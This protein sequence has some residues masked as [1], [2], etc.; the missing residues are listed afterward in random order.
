MAQ[1]NQQHGSLTHKTGSAFHFCHLQQP[2][3][4]GQTDRQTAETE[5]GR[6]RATAHPQRAES[7]TQSLSCRHHT[8]TYTQFHSTHSTQAAH[9]F[10]MAEPVKGHSDWLCIEKRSW[11]R[12]RES[13]VLPIPTRGS[14]QHTSTPL[15]AYINTLILSI[16]QSHIQQ[17][18]K[19]RKTGQCHTQGVRSTF[20]SK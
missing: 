20:Q 4:E 5:H 1:E 17:K 15:P 18:I 12:E 11:K 8:H 7:H 16:N 9:A 19:N 14:C 6:E 10:C 13:S 3:R 2:E